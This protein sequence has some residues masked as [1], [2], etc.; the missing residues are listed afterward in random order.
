MSARDIVSLDGK[1]N[2]PNRIDFIHHHL[3]ELEKATDDGIDVCG[4]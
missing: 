3:I 2:D 4:I 1:A